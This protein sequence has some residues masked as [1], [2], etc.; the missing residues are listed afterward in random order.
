MNSEPC[1]EI[2]NPWNVVAVE[3]ID[4]A[5][6]TRVMRQIAVSDGIDQFAYREAEIDALWGLVHMAV[7]AGIPG[8]AE[9]LDLLWVAHDNVADGR[10]EE[11]L[12]ALA[13]VRDHPDLESLNRD[14]W[15]VPGSPYWAGSDVVLGDVRAHP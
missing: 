1:T 7:R 11:A 13:S 8:A 2:A 4:S 6:T 3:R 14:V 12:A 5:T 9:V 10:Q 15:N